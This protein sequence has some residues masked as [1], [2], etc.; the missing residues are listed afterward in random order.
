MPQGY[1]PDFPASGYRSLPIISYG[2]W[3]KVLL[4]CASIGTEI[5]LHDS[6]SSEGFVESVQRLLLKLG[7]A[8]GFAYYD[9]TQCMLE[10]KCCIYMNVI[11]FER[12]FRLLDVF[13]GYGLNL[14]ISPMDLS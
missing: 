10:I 9:D 6:S 14:F 2:R 5:S 7:V 8:N 3:H 13:S 1:D 11:G 4:Y 12:L